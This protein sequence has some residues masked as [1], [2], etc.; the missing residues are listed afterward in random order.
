MS[1]STPPLPSQDKPLMR[2]RRMRWR[3]WWYQNPLQ[4]PAAMY[5]PPEFAALRWIKWDTSASAGASSSVVPSAVPT[6]WCSHHQ[7]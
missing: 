7:M 2:R 6:R 5:L 1:R 4:V 3:K